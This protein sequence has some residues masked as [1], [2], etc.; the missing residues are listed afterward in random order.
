MVNRVEH[1]FDCNKTVKADAPDALI[2]ERLGRLEM[3][4]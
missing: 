1:T 4:R 2:A 3:K